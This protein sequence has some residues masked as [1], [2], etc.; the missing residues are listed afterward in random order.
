M[1]VPAIP[2][3]SGDGSSGEWT[4]VGY[5]DQ[6]FRINKIDDGAAHGFSVYGQSYIDTTKAD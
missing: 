6:F 3:C 1:D 4:N 5:G 2:R